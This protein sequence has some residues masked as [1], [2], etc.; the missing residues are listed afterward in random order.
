MPIILDTQKAMRSIR[1]LQFCYLCGNSFV[2]T[3]EQ[4]SDHVP[5]SGLFAVADRN[6]PLILPTHRTC[7]ARHSADDQVIGQ[8]V[9]VIHGRKPNP[10]HKKF[11]V[12]VGRFENGSVALA[13][14]GLDLR[15]IIRRWIRGFHAALYSEY[16]PQS[17][18]FS[19]CPPLPELE[20]TADRPK[21]KPV[22]EVV[23]KFVEELKRNRATDTLDRLVWKREVPLRMRLMPQWHLDVHHGRFVSV[24]QPGDTTNFDR[25]CVG[26]YI[27]S[28]WCPDRE[29]GD[30]IGVSSCK[31]PEWIRSPTETTA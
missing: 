3:E 8:L 1:R 21:F 17:A 19:T 24:D 15:S 2:R 14:G 26:S 10:M 30:E 27:R 12:S 22:K 13:V 23:P 7:N 16:L 20:L 5:P 6:F 25:G 18:L 29:P 28:G 4:N 9:G 31:P 11:R